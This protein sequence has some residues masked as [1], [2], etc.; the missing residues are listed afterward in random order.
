M[1]G[2]GHACEQQEDHMKIV[3]GSDA[4]SPWA[5]GCFDKAAA[6]LQGIGFPEELIMNTTAERFIS[7][8]EKRRS[9]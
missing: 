7:Y 1:R 2:Y 5:V 8:I 3:V 6:M 9:L 4:H